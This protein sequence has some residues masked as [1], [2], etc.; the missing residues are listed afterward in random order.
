MI[1]K[2]VL[3]ADL[4][5]AALIVRTCLLLF[6]ST[7]STIFTLWVAVNAVR[8]SVALAGLLVEPTNRNFSLVPLVQIVTF[9]ST[10]ASGTH[11]VHT[12]ELLP[13]AF[14]NFV[15]ET[16]R[17]GCCKVDAGNFWVLLQYV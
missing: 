6:C 14:I 15:V 5:E 2:A 13:L 4:A 7:H 16:G 11:I 3:H 1:V 8:F 17:H 9:V 10:S 12:N